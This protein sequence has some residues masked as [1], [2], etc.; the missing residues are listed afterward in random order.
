MSDT[1]YPIISTWKGGGLA[2]TDIGR[3]V[4]DMTRQLSP[5]DP[6]MSNW[7]LLDLA[8]PKWITVGR[9]A[10]GIAELIGHGVKRNDF[11]D[12]P[13]PHLGY[14]VVVKGSKAPSNFG[15]SDSINISMDLGSWS[16]NTLRFEVGGLL[17]PPDLSLVTFSIY[18]GA[19]KTLASVWPCPWALAYAFTPDDDEL[20]EWDGESVEELV[21]QRPATRASFEVAWIAYL[22]APLAKGLMPPAGIAWEGTPGGGMILSA[23]QERLDQGNPDHLRRS[24]LLEAIMNERVGAGRSSAGRAGMRAGWLPARVGPY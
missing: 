4:L 18:E 8:R 1:I 6:A 22:S 5:L 9:A 3:G 21:R 11:S 2:S 13:E 15:T 19:L 10:G 16:L 24:R 14:S 17:K 12:E 20:V 23:V 7:V